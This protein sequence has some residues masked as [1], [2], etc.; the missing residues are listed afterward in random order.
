MANLWQFLPFKCLS[1][2]IQIACKIKFVNIYHPKVKAMCI[3][4][5]LPLQIFPM[6]GSTKYWQWKT[7]TNLVNGSSIC[8]SFSANIFDFTW[9][10][11]FNTS[12]IRTWLRV[13]LVKYFRQSIFQ[14]NLVIA[15]V[16]YPNSSFLARYLHKCLVDIGVATYL[17][18]GG[19]K[20]SRKAMFIMIYSNIIQLPYA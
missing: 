19:P 17:K 7:L 3:R 6:Y 15:I 1:F 13:V 10:S 4:Q 18:V 14:T 11:W 2:T 12:F 5:Y 20:S 9:S 16:N 8:Q